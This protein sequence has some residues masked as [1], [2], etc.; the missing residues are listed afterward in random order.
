MCFGFVY[1]YNFSVREDEGAYLKEFAW[2]QR[3][4][5]LATSKKQAKGLAMS[6]KQQKTSLSISAIIEYIKLGSKNWLLGDL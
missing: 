6:K 1:V 2:A 4:K 5:S 3:T